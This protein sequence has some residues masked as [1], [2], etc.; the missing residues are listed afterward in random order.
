MEFI[1]RHAESVYSMLLKD[2]SFIKDTIK[3]Y[4]YI[5]SIHIVKEFDVQIPYSSFVLSK[6]E[7]AGVL[8][9]YDVHPHKFGLY[10]KSKLYRLNDVKIISK[11]IILKNESK[12]SDV[13]KHQKNTDSEFNIYQLNTREFIDKVIKIVFNISQVGNIKKHTFTTKLFDLRE[14]DQQNNDLCI[15]HLIDVGG[16]YPASI[17]DLSVYVP[18]QDDLLRLEEETNLKWYTFISTVCDTN[19]PNKIAVAYL[20]C[21]TVK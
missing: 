2:I 6:L 15:G 8:Y 18:S 11:D 17:N 5:T 12:T 20:N 3:R 19:N 10:H 1:M 14:E 21:K 13:K 16:I 9:V 4:G 7:K